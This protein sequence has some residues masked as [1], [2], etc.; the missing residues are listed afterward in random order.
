MTKVAIQTSI[1]KTDENKLSLEFLEEYGNIF[2]SAIR[3]GFFIRNKIGRNTKQTKRQLETEISQH[4]E[5]KYKLSSVQCN[6]KPRQTHSTKWSGQTVQVLR[7]PNIILKTS[8]VGSP[9]YLPIN[10]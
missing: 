5:N 3:T 10:S 1:F 9:V 2:G 7:T 8:V 6:C 4:L